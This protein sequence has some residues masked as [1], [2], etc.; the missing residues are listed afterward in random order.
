MLLCVLP[1]ISNQLIFEIVQTHTHTFCNIERIMNHEEEDEA[2]EKYKREQGDEVDMF[3][4]DEEDESDTE[5][6]DDDDDDDG[7]SDESMSENMDSQDGETTNEGGASNEPEEVLIKLPD[8]EY[9]TKLA[10]LEAQIEQNK[11]QYQC[12]VDLIKLTR[13]QSDVVKLA[14]Y[15]QQMS[16]LYPLTETLWLEWIKDE[17]KNPGENKEEKHKRM[18]ELF[19]RAVEDYMSVDIWLEYIQYS[20][21]RIQE[22]NGHQEIRAVCER[23]I[24]FA[25]LHVT[26]G[27]L[28]WQSYLMFEQILLSTL[29][30]GNASND[31]EKEQTDRIVRLYKLQLSVCLDT[32]DDTLEELK[33]LIDSAAE[34]PDVKSL[35]ERT[36]KKYKEITPFEDALVKEED[37]AKRLEAY[38]KY[39][40]YELKLVRDLFE[41]MKGKASSEKSDMEEF[42]Y[43]RRRLKCLF[44]RAIADNSNCLDTDLWLKYTL[45]LVSCFLN[46]K[47]RLD[48]FYNQ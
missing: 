3:N 18:V 43:Q 31:K 33:T 32:I 10:E 37:P 48:L 6:G 19:E 21:S 8:Q 36:V 9:Q 28:L 23:A 2:Y 27:S 24:R 12:Y 17:T 7:E 40:D 39:L 47:I 13:N 15:R 34:A 29:M 16:Q 14:L 26:K 35:Y 4:S 11:Y 45:Y 30:T 22:P 1:L 20:L 38:N 41:Q 44:E 5:S 46:I 25:G 42:D